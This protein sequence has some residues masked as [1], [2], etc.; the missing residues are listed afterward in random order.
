MYV[1]M[2][3]SWGGTR[4]KTGGNAQPCVPFSPKL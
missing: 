4:V 3:G 1:E 2:V